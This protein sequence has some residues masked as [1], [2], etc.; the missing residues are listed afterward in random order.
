M[1]T[2]VIFGQGEKQLIDF[3]IAGH[4]VTASAGHPIWLDRSKWVDAR[5]WQ[6]AGITPVYCTAF[7]SASSKSATFSLWFMT[8]PSRP[9]RNTVGRMLMP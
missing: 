1:V 7:R 4:T 2:D 3:E 6:P 8:R 5:R 9:T